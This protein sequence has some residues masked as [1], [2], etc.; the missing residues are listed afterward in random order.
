VMLRVGS[1]WLAN[2]SISCQQSQDIAY[3]ALRGAAPNTHIASFGNSDPRNLTD[4]V[5]VIGIDTPPPVVS[6]VSSLNFFKAI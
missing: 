1:F 3:S 2:M 6:D 5:P 4:W